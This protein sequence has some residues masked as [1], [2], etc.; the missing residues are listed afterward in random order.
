[1]LQEISLKKHTLIGLLICFSFKNKENLFKGSPT[2][3][4]KEDVT[5]N[6]NPIES[7]LI[8]CFPSV[9]SQLQEGNLSSNVIERDFAMFSLALKEDRANLL[10]RVGPVKICNLLTI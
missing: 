8:P 4:A 10:Q 2:I 1:M 9:S 5:N 6:L 7:I 3:E